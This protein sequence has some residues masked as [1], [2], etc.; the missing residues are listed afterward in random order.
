MYGY[1]NY[2]ASY[3]L[4]QV[5]KFII[6]HFQGAVHR[7]NGWYGMTCFIVLRSHLITLI[8]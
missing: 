7:Q 2:Q 8:I 1:N 4:T 5:V 6:Y 3:L